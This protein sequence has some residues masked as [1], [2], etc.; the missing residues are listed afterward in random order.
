MNILN[1]FLYAIGYYPT[2][3]EEPEIKISFKSK[4]KEPSWNRS[5]YNNRCKATW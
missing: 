3:T 1:K 4:R 2:L 5:I